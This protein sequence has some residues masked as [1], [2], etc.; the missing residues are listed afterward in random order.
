MRATWAWCARTSRT[1]PRSSHD[2]EDHMQA[3]A[4]LVPQGSRVLDLGC[5]DG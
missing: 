2:R 5:G 3:I 4:R 1:S